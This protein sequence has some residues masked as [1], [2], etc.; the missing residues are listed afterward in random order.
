MRNNFLANIGLFYQFML[1]ENPYKEA[2]FTGWIVILIFTI[3]V[4]V[5]A[6]NLL[7]ALLSETFTNVTAHMQ[8]NHT[9][10]MCSI[11]IEISGLKLCF[12]KEDLEMKCLHFVR[13]ASKKIKLA[14]ENDDLETKVRDI[15]KEMSNVKETQYNMNDHILDM[16]DKQDR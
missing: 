7:I 14:G 6:L 11:L 2:S 1:G 13:Y 4:Q 12:N 9:R 3:L 15:Q 5:V 16:K 8:A 10:T